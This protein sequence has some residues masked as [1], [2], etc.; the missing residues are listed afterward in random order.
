MNQA[1]IG[2]N[3][4]NAKNFSVSS[5]GNT[6]YSALLG[7]A[8]FNS[9]AF[10]I[11]SV[12]ESIPVLNSANYGD[13]V[14]N[15]L[16]FLDTVSIEHGHHNL[17]VGG[18][19]RFQQLLTFN[20]PL[21][22]LNFG[23]GQTAGV[24]TSAFTVNSGNGF[25]SLLLAAPSSGSIQTYSS[26]PR[27]ISSYFAIFAQDDY[28]PLPNLTLNLGLRYDVDVPRHEA[29]NRTSNFSESIVDPLSG[30]PG[31]LY[32]GTTCN[33]NAKFLNAWL[34]DVAPRLGFAYSPSQ[35][36]GKMVVRGSYSILYAPLFYADGGVQ[37]NTGY[38][39]NS[40]FTSSNGFD[41]AFNLN[42]GYPSFQAP[43]ILNPS[44]FEG[45]VVASNYIRSNM[46]KPAMTQQYTLEI[47]QELQPDLIFTLGYSGERW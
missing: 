41:A 10:P 31:A 2:L 19:Y 27:W 39:A 30:K 46:N 11:T 25:A 47:Q 5:G 8:N 21:P 37:M 18:D 7:I 14:D 32:F 1:T 12:G 38:K 35:A 15:G 6:N 20:G 3:R 17:R 4:T 28:K 43:P 40:S 29:R 24:G 13:P 16:R 44:Y 34:G 36:N 9:P 22:R 45:Q 42:N 23:R 33:C 26:Q